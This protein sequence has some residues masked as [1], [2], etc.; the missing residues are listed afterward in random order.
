MERGVNVLPQCGEEVPA[1]ASIVVEGLRVAAVWGASMPSARF[2][3]LLSTTR[4]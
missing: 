2:R 3:I 1:A 4:W